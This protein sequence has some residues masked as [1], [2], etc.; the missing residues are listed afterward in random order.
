LEEKES[1][2]LTKKRIPETKK[3]R[4]VTKNTMAKYQSASC[5]IGSLMVQN[6]MQFNHNK[7]KEYY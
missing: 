5:S 4:T 7:S 6:V 3:P 1:V 2:L